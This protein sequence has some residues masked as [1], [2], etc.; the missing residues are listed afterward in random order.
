MNF[1]QT[2]SGGILLASGLSIPVTLGLFLLMA[3]LISQPAKLEGSSDTE[4]FIEF[5][6]SVPKSHQEV[7]RRSLPKKPEAPKAPPKMPKMAV[8]ASSQA[9]S[10]AIKADIPMLNSPLAL[11]DGP[12]VGGAVGAGSN[13]QGN[14]DVM[15]LVRIEPQYP[16]KA[17]RSGKEGWVQ[18]KFDV[19]A[20][21]EVEN[22]SIMQSKPGRI[23]NQAAKRALLKWKYRPMIVDG[24]P[25]MRKGLMVQLDFKIQR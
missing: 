19:T 13:P 21:G 11:G 9:K 10:T 3:H 6:R 1:T 8:K 20:T 22:V 14:S 7:R 4:N 24:K 5:V 23:F 15:P 17:A 16:I 2:K 18:L 12:Y 25:Q